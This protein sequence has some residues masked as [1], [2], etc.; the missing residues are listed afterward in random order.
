MRLSMCWRSRRL[1]II[2][3]ALLLIAA[4]PAAFAQAK[5]AQLAPFPEPNEEILG[6]PANGKLYVLADSL[7]GPIWASTCLGYE[8]GPVTDPWTKKKPMALP[9]HHVALT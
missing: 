8:Y 4:A 3:L 9:A 6:V 5:W 7:S 1:R 2:R